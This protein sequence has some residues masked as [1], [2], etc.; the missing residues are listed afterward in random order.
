MPDS[1]RT[2]FRVLIVDDAAAM[3][4]DFD[5]IF[6]AEPDDGGAEL[7]EM[8]ADLFGARERNTLAG[9]AFTLAHADECDA[10]VAMTRAALSRGEPFDVAFVDMKMPP[11]PDGVETTRRL[12]TLDP[13]LQVVLCTASRDFRWAD[14]MQSLGSTVNLHLLRKP[15]LP[16]QARHIAGVLSAKA[17]RLRRIAA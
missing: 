12:W 14:V 5:R 3:H 10:A 16:A 2:P 1:A 17:A 4:R 13:V 15:F 6:A 11:G 9:G 7:D 8:A